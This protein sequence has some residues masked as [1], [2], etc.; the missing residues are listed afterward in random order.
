VSKEAVNDIGADG[1]NIGIMPGESNLTLENLLDAMLIKSANETANIIAENIGGSRS[2]FVEMM[3]NKAAELGASNTH[4]VNPCGKDDAREDVQ[5]LSTARD[6]AAIARYAMTIPKFREIVDN[7]YYND[8]PVTNKHQK[9][10]ALRTSNKLLWD[11]NAYPYT[12][13]GKRYNYTVN[14]IKTGYTAAAGNNLISS[15]VNGDGMELIAAVMHVTESNKVFGYTKELLKYGFENYAI[16]EAA[17]ANQVL[18]SIVVKGAKDSGDLKLLT[19]SDLQ[20][21]LPIDKDQWN[22]ESKENISLPINAPVKQG[23]VL[24]YIEYERNGI[25][26]GKVNV[27]AS[28]TVEKGAIEV[29]KDIAENTLDN[30]IART[31]IIVFAVSFG[32]ILLRKTL[33]KIS[34][35]RKKRNFTV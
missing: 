31:I 28:R 33:R 21:A 20:C 17:E 12:I 13:D 4:F 24:G 10:D 30:A 1:M 7:E 29:V 5:H 26:L 8:M 14:G 15:A 27:I 34:R 22:I 32:F 3:N 6:M 25:S 18:K 23:E 11:T 9:W 2:A 35:K 16:Q 19:A